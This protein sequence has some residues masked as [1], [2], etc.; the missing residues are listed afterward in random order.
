MKS[1]KHRNETNPV[2]YLGVAVEHFCK[3]ECIDSENPL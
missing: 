3:D 1:I 2:N